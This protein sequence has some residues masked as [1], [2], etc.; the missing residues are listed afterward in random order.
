MADYLIQGN[1]TDWPIGTAVIEVSIIGEDGNSDFSYVALSTGDY[2]LIWTADPG[3]NVWVQFRAEAYN[4]YRITAL[5]LFGPFL[6]E[7]IGVAN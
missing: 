4:P 2:S 6:I 5:K 1:V 7:D 3:D